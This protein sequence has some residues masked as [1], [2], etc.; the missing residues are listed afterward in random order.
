MSVLPL[1][2]ALAPV[3]LACVLALALPPVL[4]AVLARIVGAGPAL[5]S[6][7]VGAAVGLG[8]CL[9][10][11][12]RHALGPSLVDSPRAS[13]PF[14]AALVVFGVA[15]LLRPWWGDLRRQ[16][17]TRG[18]L[19]VGLLVGAVPAAAFVGAQRSTAVGDHALMTVDETRAWWRIRLDPW[20][21]HAL[22]ALGW[23][24]QR[25][26]ET[27]RLAYLRAARAEALGARLS[28]VRTLQAT[29]RAA[30]GACDE[31]R[32]LFDE[33]L[34]ARATEALARDEAL[35]LEYPLPEALIRHCELTPAEP[36][37]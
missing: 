22:L 34:R 18:P 20:D 5:P 12:G 7:A 19:L 37:L 4:R 3:A 11:A 17:W 6:A 15:W 30:A 27:S 31:A 9:A 35:D 28:E 24:A 26:D 25:R 21:P 23:A 32:R 2:E 10:A 36:R 14:A 13:W 33:A 16:R 29:L 1:D 8:I